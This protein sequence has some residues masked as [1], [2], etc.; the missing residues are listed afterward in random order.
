VKYIAYLD[1][2]TGS[3]FIQAII[4]VLLAGIVAFRGFFGGMVSKIRGLFNRKKLSD[5][6]ENES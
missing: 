2:G 3:L 5:D 1:P 4:G 6:E